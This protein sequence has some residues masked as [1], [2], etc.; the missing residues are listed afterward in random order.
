M[1]MK[2]LIAS[3]LPYY[4]YHYHYHLA[5]TNSKSFERINISIVVQFQNHLNT[6][7]CMEHFLSFRYRFRTHVSFMALRCSVATL[8]SCILKPNPCKFFMARRC[9]FSYSFSFSCSLCFYIIIS[10]YTLSRTWNVPTDLFVD[11]SRLQAVCD[12]TSRRV[13]HLSFYIKNSSIIFTNIRSYPYINN[14]KTFYYEPLNYPPIYVTYMCSVSL[15][16][17]VY[18]DVCLCA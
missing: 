5:K 9:R 18:H 12:L 13:S 11:F 4:H 1:P 16:L 15:C 14:V 10:S 8:I 6:Y 7:I 2:S 3:T 17:G